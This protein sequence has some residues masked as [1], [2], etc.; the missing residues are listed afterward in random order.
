[1]LLEKNGKKV[2]LDSEISIEAFLSDGW[3]EVEDKPQKV[4]EPSV[5]PE[6]KA[7]TKTKK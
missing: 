1:M 5:K 7:T 3:V 2:V 4:A 6:K